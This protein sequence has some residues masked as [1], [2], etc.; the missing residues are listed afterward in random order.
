MAVRIRTASKI[1]YC[2]RSSWRRLQKI[3]EK[4]PDI[5]VIVVDINQAR[6]DGWNSDTLPIYEPGQ[7]L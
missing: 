5:K 6:I 7:L 3:A 1:V 2:A 4:C